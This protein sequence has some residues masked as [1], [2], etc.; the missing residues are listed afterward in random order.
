MQHVRWL[1]VAILTLLLSHV[2]PAPYKWHYVGE[3]PFKPRD[4]HS[5]TSIRNILW[6]HGGWNPALYKRRTTSEIWTTESPE[7][8]ASWVF[9]GQAVWEPRHSFSMIKHEGALFLIGGDVQQ[10]HYQNDVW[11]S[12]DGTTFRELV[13][14]AP[15]GPRTLGLAAS[16]KKRLWLYGGQTMNEFAGGGED[17]LYRDAWSSQDGIVWR[18][19]AD[20]LPFLPRGLIDRLVVH[21][22]YLWVIGGGTYRS[23]RGPAINY[24]DV[25]RTADGIDWKR[26]GDAPWPARRYTNVE[27]HDNKLWIVSGVD[28]NNQ[29]MADTWYSSDG[30][31]WW[32]VA[33]PFAARHAAGLATHDGN[34][35][36]VSGNNME[37]DV[38]MLRKL[39]WRCFIGFCS[40]SYR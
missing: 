2:P 21:N 37:S 33:S 39:V 30:E 29:N 31:K 11:T 16:F 34:L 17:V 38:W 28:A 12:R 18:K 35:F 15:W 4:G 3:A 1:I 22:G 19:E 23:S 40:S 20:N 6:L 9:R 25:W 27:V 24:R 14:N 32:A 10:G 13:R 8:P 7:A 36:L 26:V 5:L